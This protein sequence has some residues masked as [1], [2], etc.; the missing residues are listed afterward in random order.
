[1][2]HFTLAE[3][4]AS[5]TAT[6]LQIDNA[7]PDH[8]LPAA[9]QTLLM[10]ERIRQRLSAV[11]GRDIPIRISSGYRCLALNWA[12]KSASTSDHVAAAAAD[13]TAPSFGT[14]FAIC[15]ALL[16]H[17]DKLGIGQLIHE[18]GAWVHTST[19]RAN[20]INR[21]ITVTHAGTTTGIQEA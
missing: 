5:D 10:L 6:R 8:L 11:A 2:S 20:T 15:Q 9:E 7:L 3:F 18:F 13:W 4:S 12:L 16:P 19:R 21:A 17:L 1:M 14:P